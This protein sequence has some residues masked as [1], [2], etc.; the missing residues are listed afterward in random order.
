MTQLYKLK[1]KKIINLN[2]LLLQP[3]IDELNSCC[4]RNGEVYLDKVKEEVCTLCFSYKD[5]PIYGMRDD[6]AGLLGRKDEWLKVIPQADALYNAIKISYSN[7]VPGKRDLVDLG[8]PS[9]TRWA[10]RNIGALL[11]TDCGDH[12][13][14]G[15]LVTLTDNVS[16]YS[17]TS[18]RGNLLPE[19]DVAT[20]LWG[21][22]FRMPTKDDI[23][24]L[25]NFCV[26]ALFGN[27]NESKKGGLLLV[28][29]VNGNSIFLP[30]NDS[31]MEGHYW[32]STASRR[33][34]NLAYEIN[35]APGRTVLT[36]GERA[37]GRSIR[38]VSSTDKY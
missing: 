24:E 38:P 25:L 13:R 28:S 30:A 6:V 1:R 21:P 7:A 5:V 26:S 34:Y 8:L 11:P 36:S 3:L 9:G 18:C 2:K 32:S 35:F 37:G 17:Y 31:W 29:T 23:K 10:S 16:E 15:E 12:Y 14:W 27:F 19:N 20:Y 4:P 22:D 33:A